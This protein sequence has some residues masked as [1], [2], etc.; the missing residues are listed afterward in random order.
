[1]SSEFFELVGRA[2]LFVQLVM[3]V[4]V[5]ASILSWVLIIYRGQLLRQACAMWACF[6]RQFWDGGDLDA[7]FDD[8]KTVEP[9]AP[10][11]LFVS[12]YRT[13]KETEGA[14]LGLKER[15]VLVEQ[16]MSIAQ[17]RCCDFLACDVSVL[18]T[19]GSMSPYIGLL[20]TVWGVMNA[21]NA[22]GQLNS[23][24]IAMVAPG[25]SEALITTAMGLF[26]A[27][28]ASIAYNRYSAQI[29]ALS[30]QLER[31][32]REF[33]HLMVRQSQL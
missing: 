25:I 30:G 5:F 14:Q 32:S 8:V 10:T 20:G 15:C 27:I 11:H 29:N 16:A 4:L 33:I 6:E 17:R 3:A 9:V 31:F 19:I 23:V 12:G 7:L 1:M 28:P 21:F 22:L 18:A 13:L 24:T 26:S 2:G